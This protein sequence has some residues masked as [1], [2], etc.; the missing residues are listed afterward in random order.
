MCSS[1]YH[2]WSAPVLL[3]PETR[4]FSH[5]TVTVLEEHNLQRN[6]HSSS[7]PTASNSAD[8]A[9]AVLLFPYKLIMPL[10]TLRLTFSKQ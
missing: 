4:S 2:S 10:H 3:L 8:I 9:G 5:L 1:D 7:G 6:H